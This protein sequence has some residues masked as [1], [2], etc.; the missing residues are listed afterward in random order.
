MQF[1]WPI[2]ADYRVIYLN[3]DY[4]QTV[5]G[6]NKL[7][8]VWIMARTPAISDADYTSIIKFIAEQ[9]YDT[10]LIRPVP[11]QKQTTGG[12]QP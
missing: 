3:E 12:G 2:K 6:R 10:S 11:Q 1:I 9:G 5:I 7:D 8:Y 4:T